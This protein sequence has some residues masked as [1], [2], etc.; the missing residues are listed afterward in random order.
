M[1]NESHKNEYDLRLRVV[2]SELSCSSLNPPHFQ[3]HAN[4]F[5]NNKK[6]EKYV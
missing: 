6:P 1:Q 4:I 3:Y 5:G 2:M